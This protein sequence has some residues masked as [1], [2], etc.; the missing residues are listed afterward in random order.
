MEPLHT[1]SSYI[2]SAGVG[3]GIPFVTMCSDF[4]DGGCYVWYFTSSKMFV[5]CLESFVV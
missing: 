2:S 1:R 5:I 3:S 4:S